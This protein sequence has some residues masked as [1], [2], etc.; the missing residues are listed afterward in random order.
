MV[1][2]NIRLPNVR[3]TIIPDPGY[4][5]VDADLAGADAQ[6]VAWEAGDEKL[7]SAFSAGAAIHVGARAA[8]YD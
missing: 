8:E 5:I 6:V 3:R 4:T 1:A 7:K 2:A